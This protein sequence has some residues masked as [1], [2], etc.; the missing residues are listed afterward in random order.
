MSQ[1]QFIFSSVEGLGKIFAVRLHRYPIPAEVCTVQSIGGPG[2]TCFTTCT[3]RVIAVQMIA[4][5]VLCKDKLTRNSLT[6][7]AAGSAP[8]RPAW[9]GWWW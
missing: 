1:P 6:R 8:S 7:A 2:K 5:S 3:F 9:R 4:G